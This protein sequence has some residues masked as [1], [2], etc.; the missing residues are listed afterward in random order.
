MSGKKCAP[1]RLLDYTADPAYDYSEDI[2][3]INRLTEEQMKRII[4]KTMLWELRDEYASSEMAVKFA[5]EI[6]VPPLKFDSAHRFIRFLL[7]AH[8]RQ[9]LGKDELSKETE[10]SGLSQ[11]FLRL[12][13]ESAEKYASRFNEMYRVTFG[14]APFLNSICWRIDV[15]T[16]DTKRNDEPEI[17]IF[18]DLDLIET[19]NKERE[20]FVFEMKE[21]TLYTF[22]KALGDIATEISENRAKWIPKKSDT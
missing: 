2:Q 19:D 17:R 3:T 12:F 11:T 13:F 10:I 4:G 14:Y 5:E 21:E 16:A 7:V 15:K 8:Y 1:S 9:K 20:R 6:G 18:M 22:T